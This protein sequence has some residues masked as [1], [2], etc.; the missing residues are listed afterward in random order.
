[1]TKSY[2]FLKNGDRL[3][4]EHASV[5]VNKESAYTEF[6]NII[7]LHAPNLSLSPLDKLHI[8]SDEIYMIA[9]AK[10]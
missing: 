3:Y 2:I 10:L 1:M 7:K 9:E 4:I 8:K 5:Y 6:S